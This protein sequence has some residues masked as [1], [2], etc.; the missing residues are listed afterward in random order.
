MPPR[1][2]IASRGMFNRRVVI[3]DLGVHRGKVILAWEDVDHY[4]YDWQDWQ[5]PGE[6]ILVGR[7]RRTIRISPSFADWHRAAE[8]VFGELHPRLRQRPFFDP[9]TLEDDALVHRVS[10]RLPLPEID[11]VEIA[12][13]GPDVVIVVHARGGGEWIH[14]DAPFIADLWLLLEILDE[15]GIAVRSS[16][17]LFLPP[18]L[19]RLAERA[20]VEDRLPPVW[21]TRR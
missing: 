20:A 16:L 2:E 8:R 12:S 7:R 18:V 5:Y 11:H 19:S 6:I 17:D 3:D 21:I 14:V 1:F 9:F 4:V 10:G 15:R 13:I